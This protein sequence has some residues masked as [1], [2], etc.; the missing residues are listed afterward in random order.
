MNNNTI[1]G[2]K[3]ICIFTYINK[4]AKDQKKRVSKY[5]PQTITEMDSWSAGTH[6]EEVRAALRCISKHLVMADTELKISDGRE[7][8]MRFSALLFFLKIRANILM[9]LLWGC[10]YSVHFQCFFFFFLLKSDLSFKKNRSKI[11]SHTPRMLEMA[12][13]VCVRHWSFQ[14]LARPSLER[15]HSGWCS[16]SVQWV[17]TAC[18]EVTAAEYHLLT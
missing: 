15:Q 12:Q 10:Q 6:T 9:S 3:F 1:W 2:V 17:A 7:A 14:R 8:L 18:S 11:L 4:Q 16:L 13:A 5:Y